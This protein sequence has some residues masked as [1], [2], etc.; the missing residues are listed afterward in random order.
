M[1]TPSIST[2]DLERE[3]AVRRERLD[4]D[5]SDLQARLS[6][7]QL[8]DEGLGYI[9]HSQG[10]D[11]FRNL[12]GSVKER[13]LPVA[14]VGIGLAWLAAGGPGPTGR[15]STTY[16][17]GPGM[18]SRAWEAGRSV[19]RQAGETE[20]A[21]RERT[22]QARAAAVGVVQQAGE[23]LDSFRDRVEQAMYATRDHAGS[24]RD[25]VTGATS[26]GYTQA[27]DYAS[28]AGDSASRMAGAAGRTASSLA[29]VVG[30]NPVILGALGIMA[31][32]L[33][34]TIVPRSDVE[35]EILAPVAGRTADAAR[36]LAQE[37]M[38]RGDRAAHAAARAGRDTTTDIKPDN[39]AG[40][41]QRSAEQEAARSPDTKDTPAPI[42]G[43]M[44]TGA[45]GSSPGIG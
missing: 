12:G 27:M 43:T 5:L 1:A 23:A 32:A 8:L 45:P 10:A 22:L 11:F 17:N 34:G 40:F 38:R 39:D 19:V 7:G 2:A 37:A 33:L 3:I 26:A 20:T 31:G 9:R 13:P 21:F 30:D 24:A 16:D 29:N 42:T 18:A 44:E 36:N 28:R 14:L 35:D 4:R 15:S 6:P 41:Y 25:R